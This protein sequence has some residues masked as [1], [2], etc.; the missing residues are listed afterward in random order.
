VKIGLIPKHSSGSIPDVY[1][2]V[3][4]FYFAFRFEKTIYI[5]SDLNTVNY[6][7]YKTPVSFID[8]EPLPNKKILFTNYFPVITGVFNP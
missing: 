4:G 8:I 7:E 3:N 2:T 6:V 1:V 5:T